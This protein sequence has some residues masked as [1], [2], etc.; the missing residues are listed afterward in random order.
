[1][2]LNLFVVSWK[3]GWNSVFLI[4]IYRYTFMMKQEL[5]WNSMRIGKDIQYISST[6]VEKATFQP[7]PDGV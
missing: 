5:F 1:M 2:N 3:S 4:F 7:L 6:G